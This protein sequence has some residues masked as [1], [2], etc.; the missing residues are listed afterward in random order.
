M[1][2]LTLFAPQFAALTPP[3][4]LK[5]KLLTFFQTS[6]AVAAKHAE[7]IA[8]DT[9]QHF[10]K[11]TPFASAPD[12][13]KLDFVNGAAGQVVAAWM[14]WEQESLADWKIEKVVEAAGPDFD[15]A[16]AE[17]EL[18]ALASSA[19]VVLFSFVDC[20]W[21]VAARSLLDERRLTERTRVVELEDLGRRGKALRAALALA[22]GRTS[23]PNVF[24]GGRSVGGFT[25][26]YADADPRLC[27]ATLCDLSADGLKALDEAGGL[28]SIPLS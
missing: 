9:V 17:A 14:K 18:R 22:T 3:P 6:D 11:G 15:A 25:D 21:C 27:D 16:A 20:P 19:D 7:H 12:A 1:A 5:S 10:M 28:S 8:S 26:G 23:L 13:L 2:A 4:W 24:V